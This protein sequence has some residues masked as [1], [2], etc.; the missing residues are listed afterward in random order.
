MYEVDPVKCEQCGETMKIIAY[1]TNA[2]S[3]QKILAH[4]GKESEQPKMHSARGPPDSFYYED[5]EASEYQYGQT[6]NW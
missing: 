5:G 4:I 2:T 1:I 6:I 3:I